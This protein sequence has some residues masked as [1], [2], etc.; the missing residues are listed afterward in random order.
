MPNFIGFAD[1]LG[2]PV[3]KKAMG[4]RKQEYSFHAIKVNTELFTPKRQV[5]F[6]TAL[7]L[8]KK[9]CAISYSAPMMALIFQGGKDN[10]MHLVFKKP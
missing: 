4:V 9:L 1:M 6:C 10:P 3:V 8:Q 5:V 7:Y 2:H